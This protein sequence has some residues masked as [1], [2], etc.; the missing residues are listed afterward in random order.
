MMPNLQPIDSQEANAEV[1]FPHSASLQACCARVRL[2]LVSTP[3]LE[4]HAVPLTLP[5]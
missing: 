5:G 3:L 1:C 2:H 4:P